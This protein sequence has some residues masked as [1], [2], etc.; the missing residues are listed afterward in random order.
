[1]VAATSSSSTR[2][3][4]AKAAGKSARTKLADVKVIFLADTYFN[5]LVL[6][7][8]WLCTLGTVRTGTVLFLIFNERRA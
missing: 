5:G 4:P 7:W 8:K 2:T 6:Y 1:V 3:P